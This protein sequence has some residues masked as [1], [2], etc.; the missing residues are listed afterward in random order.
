MTCIRARL[1]CWACVAGLLLEAA[2]PSVAQDSGAAV[3]EEAAETSL[4]AIIY[5]AGPN[6]RQ[7]VPMAEQ[8]LVEH[9]YFIRNLH[10]SGTILLA[11]PYDDD[12][13][14]I[15]LRAESLD[16]VEAIMAVDPA[17]VSGLFIGEARPF[18]AR[19]TPEGWSAD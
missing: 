13:G 19:F 4:Y 5:E 2:P 15:V 16:A 10:Q 9:F 3:R 12:G 8:G 7:G 18:I 14:L 17:V 6:W 1:A 11:G